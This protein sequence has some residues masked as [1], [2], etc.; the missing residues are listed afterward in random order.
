MPK[1][2]NSHRTS[3]YLPTTP[4]LN[5]ILQNNEKQEQFQHKLIQFLVATN[6]PFD[7]VQNPTFLKLFEFMDF[8]IQIRNSDYYEKIVKDACEYKKL[9]LYHLFSGNIYVCNTIDSWSY[10]DDKYLAISS[11]WIDEHF[12]RQSA[13]LTCKRFRRH[14]NLETLQSDVIARYGFVAAAVTANP[15]L[16]IQLVT[17][18]L[19]QLG[20]TKEVLGNSECLKDVT[21][22][23]EFLP[24]NHESAIQLDI[25][26]LNKIWG[27]NFSAKLNNNLKFLHKT[28]IEKY[29][30]IYMDS[31]GY[32]DFI[33]IFTD[34]AVFGSLVKLKSLVLFFNQC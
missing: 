28:V 15:T 4:I 5:N 22:N 24:L 10:K 17:E 16:N 23:L 9:E 1:K 6:Q 18:D 21:D 19:I 29:V 20:L 34:V 33:R 11:H 14:V 13:F 26:K 25:L 32:I 31:H 3:P 30:L 12:Q 2:I 8:P 7:V 27:R